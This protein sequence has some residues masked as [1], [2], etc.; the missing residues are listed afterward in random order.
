MSCWWWS[1][2]S[3]NSPLKLGD[4]DHGLDARRS[5]AALLIRYSMI[6]SVPRILFDV[7]RF[8]FFS[9][10]GVGIFGPPQGSRRIHQ[11]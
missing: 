1:Q 4:A 10:N 7:A 2:R 11:A 3:R 5:V 9:L 6:L 8:E